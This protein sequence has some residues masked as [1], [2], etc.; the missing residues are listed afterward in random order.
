M[1]RQGTVAR[2][3][4]AFLTAART[5]A[6][7]SLTWNPPDNGGADIKDYR[8]YRSTTPGGEKMLQKVLGSKT[9]Y[10]DTT[11]SAGVNYF[12]QVTAENKQGQGP[13]SNEVRSN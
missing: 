6:G 5:S 13:R 9:G 2:F 11:A 1:D 8:V 7:V 4:K 3:S 10:V 12:Y